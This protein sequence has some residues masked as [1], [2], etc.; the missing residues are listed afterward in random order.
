[1]KKNRVRDKFIEK[2]RETPVI[3][4]ACDKSDISR[5][6]IYKWRK[7]DS[8]FALDMDEAIEMGSDLVSDAAESVIIKGIGNGS[9]NC[10]KYWLSNR[11]KKYIR[12]IIINRINPE[13]DPEFIK[14]KTEE[15]IKQYKKWQD[16][17]F[18]KT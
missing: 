10:A 7:I 9:V 5:N 15:A 8:N 2:L 12:P 16:K 3:K 18:K 11:H 17:W 6:T 14:R 13:N 1:M 4:I